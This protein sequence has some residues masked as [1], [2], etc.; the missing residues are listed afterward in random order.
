MK[1]V[2]HVSTLKPQLISKTTIKDYAE[3]VWQKMQKAGMCEKQVLGFTNQILAK[4]TEQLKNQ[5][6]PTVA[7][8]SDLEDTASRRR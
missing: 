4:I 3:G 2:S 8:V 5:P 1:N 7:I 6:E